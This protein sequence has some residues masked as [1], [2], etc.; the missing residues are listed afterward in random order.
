MK[1]SDA[2]PFIGKLVRY[3]KV[4]RGL[5]GCGT[6]ESIIGRNI[7]L[8]CDALWA[9]DISSMELVEAQ[10]VTA[11]NLEAVEALLKAGK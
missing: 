9:P 2:K 10:E 3:R 4:G 1:A 7:I 8:D 5:W 6:V 11:D